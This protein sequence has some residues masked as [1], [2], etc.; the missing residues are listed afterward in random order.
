MTMKYITIY[1]DNQIRVSDDGLFRASAMS[2]EAY[3]LSDLK[4][5]IDER[6][7]H[8]TSGNYKT[9]KGFEYDSRAMNYITAEPFKEI[10]IQ[11]FR[12]YHDS[13]RR[14]YGFVGLT[15]D[16]E[17]QGYIYCSKPNPAH[18]HLEEELIID[19]QENRERIHSWKFNRKKLEDLRV[20]N[21]GAERFIENYLSDLLKQMDRVS[22]VDLMK[23]E[24][25]GE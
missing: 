17:E 9:V 1:K 15:P 21:R 3:K 2:L 10:E 14:G 23:G 20:R 18:I 24:P 13:Y 7:A 22:D 12:T 5:M 16:H 4:K 8:S 19:T 11:P 6:I 25:K